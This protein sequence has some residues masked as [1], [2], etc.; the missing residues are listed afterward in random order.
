MQDYPAGVQLK[1]SAARA[2][3]ADAGAGH[4]REEAPCLRA[5]GRHQ[6]RPAGATIVAF[7]TNVL[8]STARSP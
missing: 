4:A 3:R 8:S 6:G 1:T 2:E 7:A 5:K